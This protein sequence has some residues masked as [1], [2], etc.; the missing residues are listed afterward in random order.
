MHQFDAAR[1]VLTLGGYEPRARLYFA[2]AAATRQLFN[3]ETF[4]RRTDGQ[5]DRRLR[6]VANRAWAF[7]IQGRDS[8]WGTQLDEAMS[9]LPDEGVELPVLRALAEDAASS[10]AYAVRTLTTA[11]PQEAA[12]AARCAYEAADQAA[13]IE[14]GITVGSKDAEARILAHRWVQR[15]LARQEHDLRNLTHEQSSPQLYSK[16]LDQALTE[17]LLEESELLLL[18]C[19]TGT[20][21]MDEQ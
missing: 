12:W 8:P 1:L 2:L 19:W 6:V 21:R 14:L 3:F 7:L 20:S 16:V 9:C 5:I 18:S 4:T 17:P 10:V 15:E 11:E 13:I